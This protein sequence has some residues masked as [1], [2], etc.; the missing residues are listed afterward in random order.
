M[1]NDGEILITIY[2]NINSILDLKNEL[3]KQIF[4]VMK[5]SELIIEEEDYDLENDHISKMK[6]LMQLLNHLHVLIIFRTDK[7][8]D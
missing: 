3:F 5:D 2:E 1:F 8:K 7:D 4:T 6:T